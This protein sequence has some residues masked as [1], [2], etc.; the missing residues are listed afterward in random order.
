MDYTWVTIIGIVFIFLMTTLGG[1][2]VYCF[3]TQ[4]PQKLQSI[5]YGFAGGVMTAASIWSLLLPAL[6]EA[7]PTWGKLSFIP[8]AIGFLLGGLLI[9][10]VEKW[11]KLPKEGE[12]GRAKK[13]FISVT[14][15][16]IPEGLAVGF[17]FGAAHSIGTP[18]AYF[19]ALGLAIGM[20][21]Q[22]FP[23][24]A[25]VTLP[26]QT[27]LKSKNKAFLYGVWS[28]LVEPVSAVIGLLFATFLR[29]LQPWLLA[30]AAGS[31]IFVVAEE[32]LPASK[33]EDH[34]WGAWGVMLGFVV[35][36]ILDIALGA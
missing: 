34:S 3:K 35:M 11:L 24:G 7:E 1:A 30:F 15:H 26:M 12:A 9:V 17:A 13:L 33:A 32:L 2:L 4:L 5:F 27:A 21:F 14:V 28:A 10:L 23:E 8:V 19:A 18:A 20:G 36:M 25:A 22:N 6:S 31:M 16:N 29:V